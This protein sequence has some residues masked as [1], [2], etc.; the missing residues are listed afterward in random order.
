MQ[1]SAR[2]QARTDIAQLEAALGDAL[3]AFDEVDSRASRGESVEAD[4]LSSAWLGLADALNAVDDAHV[5]GTSLGE[6]AATLYAWA[7]Y[8]VSSAPT[9][10]ATHRSRFDLLVDAAELTVALKLV[11]PGVMLAR[12]LH[13]ECDA[14]IRT[15]Q[16]RAWMQR[17]LEAFSQRAYGRCFVRM[18]AANCCCTTADYGD[19]LRLLAAVEADLASAGLELDGFGAHDTREVL[20]NEVRQLRA[21]LFVCLGVIDEAAAEFRRLREQSGDSPLYDDRFRLFA[22]ENLIDIERGRFTEVVARSRAELERVGP[23]Q[24][25]PTDRCAALHDLCAALFELA[26][27]DARHAPEAVAAMRAYL[28]PEALDIHSQWFMRAYLAEVLRFTGDLVGAQHEIDLA[29]AAMRV[30]QPALESTPTFQGGDFLVAIE[31]RIAIDAHASPERL[32]EQLAKLERACGAFS[33]A[34]DSLP[35][36]SGGF[37]MLHVGSARGTLCELI[38]LEKIVRGEPDGVVA[39]VEQFMRVQARGSLATKL[40]AQVGGAMPNFSDARERLCG[41]KRGLLVYVPGPVHSHVIA[42]DRER[43]TEHTLRRMTDWAEL[44]RRYAVVMST[45]PLDAPDPAAARAEAAELGTRLA[46]ALLPDDVLARIA[47]WDEVA[48]V[49]T[50]SIGWVPFEA[51][52]VLGTEFGL[53]YALTLL[54][55]L[56]VG[57]LLE[58]RADMLEHGALPDG[59]AVIGAPVSSAGPLVWNAE[60]ERALRENWSEHAHFRSG[61]GATV[62]ALAELCGGRPAVLEVQAHGI[63][64]PKSQPP[65]GFAL[66]AEAGDDGRVF[67]DRLERLGL[68]PLLVL[69]VCGAARGPLRSGDDGMSHLGGAGLSGGA[70]AVLISG[71]ELKQ[72]ATERLNDLVYAELLAHGSSPAQALRHAR[73]ELARDPEYAEAYDHALVTVVGLGFRRV[74]QVALPQSKHAPPNTTSHAELWIAG[75]GAALGLALGIAHMRRQRRT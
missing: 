25:R 61:V 45:S 39:A 6:N 26:A 12:V 40:L 17:A 56:T 73:R 64:E 33:G 5:A 10:I 72:R 28:A 7:A 51:L 49:G 8:Y 57:C 50:D 22:L 37:G 2:A 65:A 36:R 58:R 32:R 20:E 30:Q 38:R 19:A 71:A 13:R 53:E 66:T 9:E 67:A 35:A 44:Q 34:W 15:P 1:A 4:K 42:L 11:P 59:L 46:S 41:E 68:P 47:N 48:L 16:C 21:V 14:R 24:L 55:S 52:P 54:P 75:V 63:Y 70:N 3:D 27:L 29:R 23:Y 43:A 31:T 69:S 74:P 60:R 18:E 62:R